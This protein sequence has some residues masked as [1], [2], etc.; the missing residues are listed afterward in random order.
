MPPDPPG[1]HG[2]DKALGP[3]LPYWRG[4]LVPGGR[5]P[6]GLARLTSISGLI[7]TGSN[8]IG[9]GGGLY[10]YYTASR[11]FRRGQYFEAGCD[12]VG[13][14][15]SILEGS[16]AF[17]GGHPSLPVLGGI[18]ALTDAAKDTYWGL[19]FSNREKLTL[20]AIKASGG[21]CLIGGGLSVSPALT[22]AG[23]ALYTGAV[24]FDNR[25]E[26]AALPDKVSQWWS[27]K[28]A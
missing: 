4:D 24:V 21:A 26:I 23:A 3:Q 5:L 1:S 14:T 20:G 9:I 17:R 2:E 13:G 19:R 22:I 25:K 10:N 28:Q 16:L 8:V 18:T 15:A 7:D 11:Y 27:G 12:F 6:S